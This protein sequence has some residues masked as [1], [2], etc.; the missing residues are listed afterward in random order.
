MS[1]ERQVIGDPKDVSS[2][3]GKTQRTIWT[4]V[5]VVLSIAVAIGGVTYWWGGFSFTEAETSENIEE[6]SI[7]EFVNESLR[8]S[9]EPREIKTSKHLHDFAIVDEVHNGKLILGTNIGGTPVYV[10]IPPRDKVQEF[11]FCYFQGEIEK[12]TLKE[13]GWFSDD[14]F[15]IVVDN[16]VE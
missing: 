2:W 11:D 9:K 4:T 16:T 10:E 15:Y 8:E 14:Y 1:E 6:V 3:M 5:L 13:G 7:D 12:A